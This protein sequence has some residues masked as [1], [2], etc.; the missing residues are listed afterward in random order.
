M[1]N[2]LK[3]LIE[4]VTVQKVSQ[5]EILTEKIE[6]T[7]K[8]SLLLEGIRTGSIK[9]DDDGLELL[10]PDKNHVAYTK[11]KSMLYDRLLNTLFFLDLKKYSK[12]DVG[13]SRDLAYKNFCQIVLITSQGKRP[14]AVR[15]AERLLQKCLKNEFLDLSLLLSQFLEEHYSV[16]DPD[17][18]KSHKNSFLY[19]QNISKIKE[20]R[21]ITPIWAQLARMLMIR[22]T[23]EFDD[24]IEKLEKLENSKT[25][26]SSYLFNYRLY[27]SWIFYHW[28]AADFNSQ[29]ESCQEAINYLEIK[30]R[31][32]SLQGLSFL[33]YKGIA[34]M[35]LNRVNEAE[36]TLSSI[37]NEFPITKGK[38]HWLNVYN[39]LFLVKVRR[40]KY[41]DATA[42]VFEV[43]NIKS[44]QKIDKK[45]KE[46]WLLKEAYINLLIRIEKVDIEL[47]KDVKIKSFRLN[48]FMNEVPLFYKDKRGL[49]VSILIVQ[50]IYLLLDNKTNEMHDRLDGLRQYSYR[51]LRND[52]TF[53]SNCFI[54]MLLKIPSAG[55]HHLRVE[56]HTKELKKKL[57]STPMMISAQSYEVEVI[58]YEDLW[59]IVM[60]I[61]EK[62]NSKKG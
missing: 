39:Y 26:E 25:H 21:A 31:K 59:E 37:L 2:D 54:K 22:R 16:W 45:W 9:T 34:E 43:I 50:F 53:R 38:I 1:F 24:V 62:R 49:N 7:T 32:F 36:D 33:T 17:E 4:I 48:K 27:S 41:I 61:L 40:R 52:S 13:N 55:F 51:Y 12:G 15:M 42:M 3:E 28:L 10:Y 23:K 29:L 58:P 18:K 56:N 11:L 5:I 60:E 30:K 57:F 20:L 6:L 8:S 44:F 19:E 14:M 47:V 35:H 46:P